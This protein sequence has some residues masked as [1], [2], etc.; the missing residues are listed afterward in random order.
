MLRGMAGGDSYIRCPDND[1]HC[2]LSEPPRRRLMNIFVRAHEDVKRRHV[3]TLRF[4]TA[5]SAYD[6]D[7][8]R[9]PSPIHTG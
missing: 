8:R 1:G 7:R 4:L 5:A 9:N 2:L 6:A 3:L